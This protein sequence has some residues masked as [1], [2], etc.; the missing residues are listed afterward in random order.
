[1]RNPCATKIRYWIRSIDVRHVAHAIQGRQHTPAARLVRWASRIRQRLASGRFG[2]P[3]RYGD[4][5]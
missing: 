5:R 3:D 2:F 4:E 1:M